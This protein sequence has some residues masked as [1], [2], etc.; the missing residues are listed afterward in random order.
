MLYPNCHH[1]IIHSSFN[2]NISY[3]PPYQRLVWDYKKADSKSI[4]KALDSV[5]WERLFDQLDI[6]AQVA[7]FNETILNVFRNYVPN[8]YIT[9]DDKDPVWMNENIKTKI[10]EK[11]TF[12]QKYIENGRLES[13]FILLE[14]LITELN[15]LIFS[16]KTVL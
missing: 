2:L 5:N 13:D 15:D 9:I 1:Q 7:A 8:K 3:P 6:N 11:N 16:V 12:Y 14:K 10:K 4:R